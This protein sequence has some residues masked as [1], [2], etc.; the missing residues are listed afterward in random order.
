MS[1]LKLLASS[2]NKRDDKP[3]QELAVKI[4]KLKQTD[5]IRELVENLNNRDKNIQSDCIKVLYEIGERGAAELIAPHWEAFGKLLESRNNRLVWGSMTA[6]DMIAAVDPQNI[7]KLL[8]EVTEAMTKGSV[9]TTDHGV[10][11]LARLASQ[12]EYSKEVFPLLMKQLKI[13]PAKQ[14]PMYAE[15]SVIA[16]NT[17]N[18]KEFINLLKG[19]FSELGNDSQKKRIEKVITKISGAG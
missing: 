11:I 9:I 16:V 4:I 15:K 10:S 17:S 13:C 6:L 18:K 1:V 2:L 19:R 5:W 8:P 3:N 14:L 12:Q 7:Y